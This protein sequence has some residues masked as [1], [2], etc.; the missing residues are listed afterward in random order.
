MLAK[1]FMILFIL[2]W[3]KLHV[4]IPS[5]RKLPSEDIDDASLDIS[6]SEEDDDTIED[7]DSE[8]YLSEV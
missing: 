1:C 2:S 4:F 7:L 8:G 6:T 3:Q 5:I